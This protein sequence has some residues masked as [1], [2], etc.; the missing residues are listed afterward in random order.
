M[1]GSRRIY[2]TAEADIIED[3]NFLE[4]PSYWRWGAGMDIGID[5]P[6]AY[7]LMAHDCTAARPG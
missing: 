1:V 7:V 4:F 3:V 6:W 2:Q 5:H